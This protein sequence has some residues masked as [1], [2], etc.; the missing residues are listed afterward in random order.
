M[1][2][3]DTVEI[4][5]GITAVFIRHPNADHFR[6]LL[7]RMQ[8]GVVIHHAPVAE[9]ESIPPADPPLFTDGGVPMPSRHGV[10]GYHAVS[11][12][13]VGYWKGRRE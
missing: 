10:R 8:G 2:S 9:V 7:Q 13:W 12:W 6:T 4:E 3:T 11:S 5:I 1:G